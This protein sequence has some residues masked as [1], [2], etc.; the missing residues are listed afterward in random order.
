MRM[1]HPLT[2][3]RDFGRFRLGYCLTGDIFDLSGQGGLVTRNYIPFQWDG[4]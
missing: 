2:I 1:N 3:R 4:I